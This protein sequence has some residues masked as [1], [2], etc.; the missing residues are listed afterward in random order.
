MHPDLPREEAFLGSA[1]TKRD[2]WRK[3]ANAII[4]QKWRTLECVDCH[5]KIKAPLRQAFEWMQS[6]VKEWHGRELLF[7]E[8]QYADCKTARVAAVLLES[9]KHPEL[10]VSA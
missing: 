2:A 4:N 5:T 10:T 9:I 3:A 7:T 1:T 8:E 6:H